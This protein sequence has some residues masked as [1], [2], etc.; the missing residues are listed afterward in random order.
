MPVMPRVSAMPKDMSA[1]SASRSARS[2]LVFV[3]LLSK[4][5]LALKA[6]MPKT[7]PTPAPTTATPSVM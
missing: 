7:V 3:G 2:A 1:M 4:S 5:L 6:L